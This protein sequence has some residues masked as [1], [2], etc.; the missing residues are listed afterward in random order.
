MK[1]AI[2]ERKLRGAASTNSTEMVEHLLS[3]HLASV[4]SVDEHRRSALHFA[5]AKVSVRLGYIP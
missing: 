1:T 4:K 2:A 3:G 5:A